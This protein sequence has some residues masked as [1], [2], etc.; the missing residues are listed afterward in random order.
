[1]TK[2]KCCSRFLLPPSCPRG[3]E[4]DSSN[5]R[6]VGGAKGKCRLTGKAAGGI[7]IKS[8]QTGCHSLNGAG[9]IQS[10][11]WDFEECFPSRRGRFVSVQGRWVELS[12]SK[13]FILSHCIP[14]S[15]YI[16]IQKGSKKGV[17][18]HSADHRSCCLLYTSDAAD[19]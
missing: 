9:S 3:M 19:D 11:C 1:M 17:N 8:R 2:R 18:G 10:K 16:S 14:F 13:R 5:Y 4:G 7:Q 6:T 15:C 12:I